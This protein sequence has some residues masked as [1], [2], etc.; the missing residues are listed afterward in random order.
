MEN[1]VEYAR[2]E[3]KCTPTLNLM[4]GGK[5][6]DSELSSTMDVVLHSRRVQYAPAIMKGRKRGGSCYMCSSRLLLSGAA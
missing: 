3:E 6:A 2:T 1:V 5:L 4:C